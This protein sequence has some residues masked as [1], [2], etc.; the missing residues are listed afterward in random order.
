MLK[1]NTVFLILFREGF[2][3]RGK[4]GGGGGGQEE[5]L[6]QW[7]YIPG[8][9]LKWSKLLNIFLDCTCR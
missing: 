2:R 7:S 5:K 3:G 6:A 4:G 1:E 9:F 8:H